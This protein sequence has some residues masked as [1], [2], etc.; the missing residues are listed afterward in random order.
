MRTL[1]FLFLALAAGCAGMTKPPADAPPAVAGPVKAPA[2]EKPAPKATP[3]A[4]AAA[5]G[6]H[7]APVAPATHTAPTAPAAPVAQAAAAPHLD[8]KGLEQRLKATKAIGLFTKLALKNQ[9]DD[10]LT[11]FRAYHGGQQPPTLT[12]LRPNY[13]LLIM[14]VQSLIQ[15]DDPALAADVAQSREAIW[16]VL[17][18]K[19]KFALI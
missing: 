19:N 16:G 3:A 6:A 13:E 12:D 9:V 5:S 11:K 15:K 14:K 2:D 8:L 18:D 4:S 7:A 10:L 1:A 17:A